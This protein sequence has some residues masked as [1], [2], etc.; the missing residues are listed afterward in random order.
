MGLNAHWDDFLDTLKDGVKDLADNTLKGF[1][2]QAQ[3]DAEAF[4]TFARA[5]LELWSDALTQG[6]IEEDDFEFLVGGLTK[7]AKLHGLV[8][9]GI[10]AKRLDD[11]RNGLTSLIIKTVIGMI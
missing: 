10:V 7:L 11:F 4:A 3:E 5:K 6:K 8:A 2:E 9:K 1:P